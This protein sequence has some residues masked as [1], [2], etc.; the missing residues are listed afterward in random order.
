VEGLGR[1][2]A[3]DEQLTPEE[4]ELLRAICTVLECPLPPILPDLDGG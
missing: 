3:H 4:A 1:T 2:I